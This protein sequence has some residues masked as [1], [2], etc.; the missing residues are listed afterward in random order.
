L[1]YYFFFLFDLLIASLPFLKICCC[2]LL[3]ATLDL[4]SPTVSI[5]I[6]RA[7]GFLILFTFATVALAS[8]GVANLILTVSFGLSSL[9]CRFLFWQIY[10]F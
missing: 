2:V 5:C 8:A 9:L 7:K 6:L 3:P 10:E 4:C 1:P